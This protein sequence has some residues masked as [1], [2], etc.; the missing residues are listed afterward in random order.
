MARIEPRME[1]MTQHPE[2][3]KVP[4]NNPYITDED[5]ALVLN[6][7]RKEMGLKPLV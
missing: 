3:D 1:Q 5:Y 7:W 2:F 4:C 6:I